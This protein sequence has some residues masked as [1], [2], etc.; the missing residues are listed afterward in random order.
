MRLD[1]RNDDAG[2]VI[3]KIAYN[4]RRVKGG[5]PRNGSTLAMAWHSEIFSKFIEILRKY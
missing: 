2:D 4:E 5:L 3:T 1:H